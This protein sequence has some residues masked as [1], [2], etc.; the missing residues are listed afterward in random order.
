MRA[1]STY[2][3]HNAKRWSEYSE[4][5]KVCLIIIIIIIIIESSGFLFFIDPMIT[6][7]LTESHCNIF[8]VLFPD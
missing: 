5:Y 4:V 3:S 2:F 7:E 1:V 8:H 6:Q